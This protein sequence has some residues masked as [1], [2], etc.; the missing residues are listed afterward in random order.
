MRVAKRTLILDRGAITIN[1]V[2]RRT[3]G[4][5]GV[6]SGSLYLMLACWGSVAIYEHPPASLR[7]STPLINEGGEV[8]SSRQTM[9]YGPIDTPG[10][11][12]FSYMRR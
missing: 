1:L 4:V 9:I 6:Y 5:G 3:A 12:P 2:P 10:R 11:W 8:T 7:S